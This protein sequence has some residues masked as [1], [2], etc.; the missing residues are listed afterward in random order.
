MKIKG[1]T[2]LITGAARGIGQATAFEFAK[3]GADIVGVDLHLPDMQAT[4][5]TVQKLNRKFTG[6]ACDITNDSATRKMLQHAMDSNGGFDVL[7]N[8][9]AV[10]ASGPFLE[11]DFNVWRRTIETNLTALM[12]LTHAA[13]PHL[14]KKESAHIVNVA[15]IAGKFGTEGVVA[16]AASKHGVVGFSSALRFELQKTNVGVS[17][18]CPSQAATRMGEGV[19]HTF[20]TPVVQPKDVAKAVRKAV[21]NNSPEVYVPRSQRWLVS[22]IPSLAPRFARWFSEWSKASQGWLQARKEIPTDKERGA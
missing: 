3:A 4:A 10:M 1:K 19:E 20:L 15:S 22:I 7:V 2:A 18:I 12:A 17:W 14:I 8:N 11:Q 6:L 13:L 16:Y 9:A 5:D 21:E